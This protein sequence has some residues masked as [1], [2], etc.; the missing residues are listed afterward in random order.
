MLD[1]TPTQTKNALTGATLSCA[2]CGSNNT[3]DS[4]FC[5][6]CG[7]AL[8]PGQGIAASQVAEAAVSEVVVAPAN[9]AANERQIT[10]AATPPAASVS[11]TS[12]PPPPLDSATLDSNTPRVGSRVA[13]EIDHRRAQQLLDRAFMLAER[14]DKAAAIIACRQAVSLDHNSASGYSILGLLLEQTGDIPH[15]IQA[16]EQVLQISPASLLERESL[17]RLKAMQGQTNSANIFH[18]NEE[19]LYEDAPAPAASIAD[20]T[21]PTTSTPAPVVAA[22]AGAA[23]A[24]VTAA[25][26]TTPAAP[27]AAPPPSRAP[28]QGTAPR[29]PVVV[30]PAVKRMPL[31]TGVLN[32]P[33]P[34]PGPVRPVDFGMPFQVKSDPWWVAMQRQPS[35]YFRGFPLTAATAMCLLFLLWARNWAVSKEQPVQTIT[36]TTTQVQDSAPLSPG[37]GST[38]ARANPGSPASAANGTGNNGGFPVT[39]GELK[40]TTGQPAAPGAGGQTAGGTTNQGNGNSLPPSATNG[41]GPKFPSVAPRLAP[42]VPV[43]ARRDNNNNDDNFS[44]M[45]APR[46]D[47]PDRGANAAVQVLPPDRN[48]TTDTGAASMGGAPLNPGAASRGYVRVSPYRIAP[49]SVPPRSTARAAAAEAQAN[50]AIQSGHS[51]RAA[52]ILTPSMDSGDVAFNYQSRALLF[53]E[54]GDYGRAR[55]DFQTAIN[56]YRDQIRRGDNSNSA[57]KGLQTCEDGRR[58]AQARLGG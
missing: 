49:S 47:M 56:Y 11:A 58:E 28:S 17:Q 57:R 35:F 45:P 2:A 52:D 20:V 38:N 44:G 14:G 42:A 5:R 43:P 8:T 34:A 55:D 7:V 6:H 41:T 13:D 50:Q 12:T 51:D 53:M 3:L 37:V 46:V 26:A 22:T 23:I 31:P 29:A 21:A 40:G 4:R 1:T 24:G 54:R 16:Y 19:E 39:G 25:A 9:G 36:E 48:E 18:F 30:A 33:M 15:A 32:Q 10:T 27:A